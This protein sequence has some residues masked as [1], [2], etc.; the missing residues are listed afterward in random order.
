MY[1]HKF[2]WF[3]STNLRTGTLG[4]SF[5]ISGAMKNIYF[6]DKHTIIVSS[7]SKLLFLL[8]PGGLH[9]FLSGEG[10]RLDA[11]S[12]GDGAHPGVRLL[13][14]AERGETGPVIG[15]RSSA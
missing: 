1:Q 5:N 10:M 6:T 12:R 14:P 4:E 7:A 13:V 3:R 2:T 9:C 15:R 8:F 11:A